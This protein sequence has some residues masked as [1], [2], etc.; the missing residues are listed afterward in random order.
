MSRTV[1]LIY[2][3]ALTVSAVSH[4]EDDAGVWHASVRFFPW[5]QTRTSL[6]S[7][8]PSPSQNWQK[9]F[10]L[11]APQPKRIVNQIDLRLSPDPEAVQDADRTV[12]EMLVMS[13]SG[14]NII[15]VS[16]RSP[17]PQ[18]E[19]TARQAHFIPQPE[20]IHSLY[21]AHVRSKLPQTAGVPIPSGPTPPP[22]GDWPRTAGRHRGLP[23]YEPPSSDSAPPQ[24]APPLPPRPAPRPVV[25]SSAR[26]PLP[27]RRGSGD[28]PTRQRPPPLNLDGISTFQLLDT[29]RTGRS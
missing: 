2:L 27:Q 22:L 20:P 26:P 15:P 11:A 25:P 4:Q 14:A 23:R 6:N 8:P 16:V 5:Y 3:V 28:S 24:S 29:R 9:P 18:T 13:Q 12:P 7:A 19:E 10:A 1:V 17:P 21:P